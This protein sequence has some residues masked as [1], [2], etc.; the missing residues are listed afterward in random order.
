MFGFKRDRLIT[1]EGVVRYTIGES[2]IDIMEEEVGEFVN[3][4]INKRKITSSEEQEIEK[5][6][7]LTIKRLKVLRQKEIDKHSRLLRIIK[8]KFGLT[9]EDIKKGLEAADDG[10][11]DIEEITRKSPVE[12]QGVKKI[13]DITKEI[14]GLRGKSKGK[15]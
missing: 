2:E 12:T 10:R 14:Q 6:R 8:S 7:D 15:N 4:A 5:N 11:M 9:D 3:G 1:A 13:A